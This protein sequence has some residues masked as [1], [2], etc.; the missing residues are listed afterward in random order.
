MCRFRMK[1][2]QGAKG[3]E[4]S[5]IRNAKKIMSLLRQ[6]SYVAGGGGGLTVLNTV[7]HH[8]CYPSAV[9]MRGNP[10]EIGSNLQHTF[11]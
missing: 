10:T 6:Q 9:S 3:T 1:A 4:I 5:L 7:T 11:I 8:A 2:K